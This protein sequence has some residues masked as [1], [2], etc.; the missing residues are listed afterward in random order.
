MKPLNDELLNLKE[1]KAAVFLISTIFGPVIFCAFSIYGVVVLAENYQISEF[2]WVP[3][4]AL[5]AVLMLAWIPMFAKPA[6][7]WLMNKNI[8][9][10]DETTKALV[11]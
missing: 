1:N 10:I 5:F 3:F 6:I 8:V 11:L 4:A 7:K 2:H 9:K